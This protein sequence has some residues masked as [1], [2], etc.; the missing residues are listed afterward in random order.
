M[1]PK[2][3]HY[4]GKPIG[5]ASKAVILL[6]GR[7]APAAEMLSLK[8]E[9]GLTDEEFAVVVPEAYNNS[10]Y[11][12]S[13]LAP[14]EQNEPWLSSALSTLEQ[15]ETELN[16]KGIVSGDIY[17]FG[18]SQGACL[19]LEYVTRNAKRYGGVV[20]V[21]GGLIGES[22]NTGDYIS[23]FEETPVLLATSHPDAHVPR[24]RVRKTA[25]ILEL[26][27]ARVNLQIMENGGHR[28]LPEEITLARKLF[29][30]SQGNTEL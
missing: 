19:C 9:L 21:I 1:H 4:S 13:F 3:I 8:D 17:F 11:P 29:T 2:T 25:E 18:F 27:N 30:G 24:D 7:N 5:K 16:Q 15:L 26:K 23:N 14:T 6:H 12:L 28:V 10:W 22:I 20:A